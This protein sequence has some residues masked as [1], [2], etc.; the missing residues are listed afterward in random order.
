MSQSEISLGLVD[1]EK[2]FSGTKPVEERHRIDGASLKRWMV[3]NVS[4]YA[5]PLEILQF[6]G[7]QSNPT[8]CLETPSRSYVLR[9][10]PPGKL[11]PS[12]HAVDREFKV[13]S[14]LHKAG[15]P[16]AK[17]Y[18][19]CLD[20]SVLGTMFYIMSMEAGRVFWDGALPDLDPAMRRQVYL[21]EIKTLADLHR[22][23]PEEIG[24]GDFGR[25]GN[26]CARQVERWIKQYR[27]SETE[28]IDAME[29]LIAWLP[30]TIPEQDRV[31]IVH[32]DYRLNNMIFYPDE[33]RVR[34]VLDWELST[35][36]NP[37][38]DFANVLISWAVP[39]DGRANLKG[40]DLAALGIPS[41]EEIIEAYRVASGRSNIPDVDWYLAYNLFRLAAIMQG[42]AARARDGTASS[43]RAAEEGRTAIP[44]A[45]I[46]WQ[47]AQRAGA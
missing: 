27:A 15:F 40:L 13:I 6:K 14:A 47:F 42:I 19:L 9:R 8:Y 1:S 2:L 34:A 46:A 39:Y 16:V 12:A 38:A 10:K 4:D 22:L 18:G 28:K 5:G 24:L 29:R 3:E 44:L 36:G 41:M 23:N 17:P 33:P 26:Y 11:L 37:L 31:S 45:A 35:L 32:G 25:P 30:G 7:G 20:E 43:S 21:A